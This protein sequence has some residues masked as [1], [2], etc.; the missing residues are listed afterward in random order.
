MDRVIELDGLS[1]PGRDEEVFNPHT[2]RD[3]KLQPHAGNTS[4]SL[5]NGFV[6]YEPYP[7]LLPNQH[8]AR[9]LVVR[10]RRKMCSRNSY[11]QVVK[12]ERQAFKNPSP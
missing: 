1:G 3:I 9:G 4:N 6:T 10:A 7:P 5:Q 12:H 8:E 11:R 2:Q